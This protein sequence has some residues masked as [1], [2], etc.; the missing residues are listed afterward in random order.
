M[1]ESQCAWIIFPLHDVH[2]FHNE[3]I[4]FQIWIGCFHQPHGHVYPCGSLCVPHQERQWMDFV[5]RQQ[6]LGISKSTKG[7]R[8]HL[9]LQAKVV[10]LNQQLINLIINFFYIA[11]PWFCSRKANVHFQIVC[12]CRVGIGYHKMERWN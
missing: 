9:F 10:F 7:S 12:T 3:C 2:F 8:I 5:Q 1:C 11:Y 6:S 4:E